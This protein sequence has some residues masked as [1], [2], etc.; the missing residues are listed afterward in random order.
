MSPTVFR[1]GRFRFFFFSREERRMHV[2]VH[3]ANGEGK[4]LAGAPP[5]AQNYGLN[6]SDLKAAEALIKEHGDEI[7]KAWARHF[8]S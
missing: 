2:H 3:S 1:E 8:T 5:L 4:I 6:S 7:R